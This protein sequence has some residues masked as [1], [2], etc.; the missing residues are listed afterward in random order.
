MFLQSFYVC[1]S[2]KRKRRQVSLFSVLGS[3]QVKA[4]C[5]TWVKLTPGVNVI[6][7]LRT[8]IMLVDRKNDSQVICHFGLLRSTCVKAL[9]KHVSEIDTW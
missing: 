4:L 1:R 5:K 8:A 2:S 3:G 6:N 7:I 9:R